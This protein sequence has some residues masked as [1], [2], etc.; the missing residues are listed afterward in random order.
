MDQALAA[1]GSVD[2]EWTTHVDSVW[3]DLPF[4]LPELN[5]GV[6]EEVLRAGDRLSTANQPASPLGLVIVGPGGAG[7]THVLSSLRAASFT[8]GSFFVLVDMTDVH[9]FW[10]TVLLGYI[11]SLAQITAG[12]RSQHE[13]LLEHL[14]SE[15]G[16]GGS[17]A[18]DLRS[19]RPPKLIN[20]CNSIIAGLRRKHPGLREHQDAVRAIVLLASDDFEL[21]DL[22]YKWLQ[23]LGIDEDEKLHHGFNESRRAPIEIVRGL[24]QLMSIKAPTILALDQL[25]AIVAEQQLASLGPVPELTDETQPSASAAARAIIQGIARGLSAL[26]D[27]TRRTQIVLS[28]L[29]QTWNV[30]DTRTIVTMRD[31]FQPAL[32]LKA[33][34]DP[35]VVRRLVETRLAPAYAAMAFSPKYPSYPFSPSF[36]AGLSGLLPREVLKRC[37]EHRMACQRAGVITEA[38][39]TEMV[40]LP[41]AKPDNRTIEDEFA[42]LK[43][44]ADVERLLADEDE[45]AL[46][47]LLEAAC[48]ALKFENPLPDGVDAHVDLDFLGSGNA[49]PLHARLRLVFRANERE[50]HLSV[51]FLQ[52]S[53]YRAFQSRLK[54]AITASGIDQALPFRQLLILRRGEVP[55]GPATAKIVG[56]LKARGGQVLEP[57]LDDLRVLWALARMVRDRAPSPAVQDWL[58]K[59][60]IVSR[61]A[62]FKQA[63]S[64]LFDDVAP[65]A[66]AEPPPS[67]APPS[68]PE[69]APPPPPGGAPKGL[70]VG[71]RLVGQ[72]RKDALLIPLDNLVKHTVVIAGAGSGKTVLLRRIVEEAAL[73]GVPSIVIDGA[74]DLS[75]LGQRWPAW[76]DGLDEKDRAKAESYAASAEVVVWTPGRQDGNPL[77]LDPLPKFADVAD[78]A[79]ELEAAVLMAR[80]SLEPIAIGKPGPATKVKAGILAAALRYFAREKGES[81]QE[82]VALLSELP[83]DVDA[84]FDKAE[85]HARAVADA[86][87]AEMQINPLLRGTGASLD[88]G[89]LLRSKKAGA[90]RV[91]V[92]NLSG[93]PDQSSQQHLV[94]QL[95]M[96]LFTW[97]KKNPAKGRVLQGLLVIDE[98]RDFVPSQKTVPSR[99]SLIRL[100][101]QARKYGLGIVFATQAPKSIDHNVIAN[102]STHF[103]GRANSPEAISTVQQLLQQHGSSGSDLAALPKGTFYVASE[104]MPLQ[105]IQTSLCLSHHPSSPPD[106]G[107]IQRMARASRPMVG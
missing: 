103:Y 13:V 66:A 16:M 71:T 45:E 54:A 77:V 83:Q 58:R 15:G 35:A 4:D 36:F 80:G 33:V 57:S 38:T 95:A 56:D 1:L 89:A 12:G 60:R 20:L 28:C 19:T 73:A 7:K 87:R 6:R 63:A 107:E 5:H 29:E 78:S 91:S 43:A 17:A 39:G 2:L 22:G 18:A 55:G 27:V 64:Y 90:V 48:Q 42:A 76:P 97:L 11:R 104:G 62:T 31:R 23:G 98:A 81:L 25:D 30:L 59:E 72:T 75:R 44:K 41:V 14:A 69:P 68:A 86:I 94:N 105:K 32:K 88:P 92:V 67:A 26:R 65:R 8:R 9:D 93:L 101:A 82:L 79:D 49:V 3:R 46:D 24:S 51:R 84:D 106:E 99:D 21:Q 85:K 10:E 70:F 47:T 37:N 52:K 102:C 96:T 50:K 40:T 74:N 53:H 100:A 34:T 61:L